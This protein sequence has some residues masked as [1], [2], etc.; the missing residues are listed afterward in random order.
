LKV[1]RIFPVIEILSPLLLLV[2]LGLLLARLKFLGRDFMAD[3]NKLVF[4]VALP[5]LLFRSVTHA[6]TPSP[7][8][9]SLLGLL[10]LGTAF[11][12]TAGWI[13]A[14]LLK[15]PHTCSGTLAQSAFRGNLTYIGI[16]VLTYALE[17]SSGRRETFA[18]AVI[19]MAL[20]MAFYNILAVVVLSNGAKS[21]SPWRTA[22][23]SIFTN[24]L[25]LSGMAGFPL[26]VTQ[27]HLPIFLDRA[28]ETLGG[29]AVPIALLCIGGSL[30][31][32]RLGARI[33]GITTAALLKTMVLPIFVYLAAPLFGINGDDLRVALVFAACPTA[34]A[35]FVMVQ[36][37]NGDEPLASGA[38]VLSTIL[39]GVSIPLALFLS[40]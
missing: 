34:A 6:E 31:H 13:G 1:D 21:K 16:P 23:R 27:T 17:E 7:A 3:L 26:A 2:L 8:T 22:L 33:G 29:V 36:Q 28:L 30:A 18:T 35:S 25:L 4:W 11:I 24:P 14:R 20:M 19:V 10:L 38:I 32:A 40:R 39:A 37:M 9:L 12:A 15:M 5:A